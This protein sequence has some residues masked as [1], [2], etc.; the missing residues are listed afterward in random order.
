MKLYF[1][2]LLSCPMISNRDCQNAKWSLI[3][4]I[5]FAHFSD[6][7]TSEKLKTLNL[8]FKMILHWMILDSVPGL[9]KDLSVL[10]TSRL[11]PEP[12]RPLIQ[13]VP[14]PYPGWSRRRSRYA[15]QLPSSIAGVKND[16]SNTVGLAVW[17]R[18][19]YRDKFRFYFE[20]PS[21]VWF[22]KSYVTL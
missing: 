6:I 16:W 17:F 20:T 10:K 19:E 22:I 5:K 2:I 3:R 14:G 7:I 21:P 13:W 1:R 9:N 12:N 4:R 11:A 18:G 15:N 8:N